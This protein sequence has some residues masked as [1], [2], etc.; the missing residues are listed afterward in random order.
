MVKIKDPDNVIT[1]FLEGLGRSHLRRRIERIYLFG[2]R[3]KGTE[4]PNSDY[5]LLIVAPAPDKEFKSD[6]YDIVVD[7]LLETGRGVSLKIFK[8]GEFNRLRKMQTPFMQNVLKE[9]I[10]LG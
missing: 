7:I 3:A 10:R 6:I 2:S 4:R 9:G 5:D 8:T 1:S